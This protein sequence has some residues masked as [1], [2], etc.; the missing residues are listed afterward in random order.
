MKLLRALPLILALCLA[1]FGQDQTKSQSTTIN[2]INVTP[3]VLTCPTSF[4]SAKVIGGVGQAYKNSDGSPVQCSASGGI[5]PY[6]WSIVS[7]SLPTG[8]TLTGAGTNNANGFIGGTPGAAA[9]TSTATIQVADSA[10]TIA[11]IQLQW[12]ASP[13]TVASYN[14]YR[15]TATGGPYTLIG[16][17]TGQLTF[18]DRVLRTP[19][20]TL[21]YVATAV[22]S[23]A[24]ESVY[25]NEA[26]ANIK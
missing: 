18:L 26:P 7:G 19:T 9:T 23:S 15:G 10:G 17:A 12:N 21:Y 22:D 2:V 3:V 25:S 5:V 13:S 1:S 4:P 14:M 11:S 20:R 24:K 6:K 8:L 16:S